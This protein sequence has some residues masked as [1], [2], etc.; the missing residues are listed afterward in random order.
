M[1]F[2]LKDLPVL[3]VLVVVEFILLIS[4]GDGR[5]NMVEESL[6]CLLCG[7]ESHNQGGTILGAR[8]VLHWRF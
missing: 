5:S 4:F 7:A 6:L 2:Q 1:S 3:S 8:A